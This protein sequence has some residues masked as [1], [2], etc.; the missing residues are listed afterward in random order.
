MAIKKEIEDVS[1][2][3]SIPPSEKR[4]LLE[5]L[6]AEFQAAEP[7]LFLSNIELVRKHY[8]KR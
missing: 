3:K 2:D 5:K 1:S 7:I 8:D 4:N 6:H